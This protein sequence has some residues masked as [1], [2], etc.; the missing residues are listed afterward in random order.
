MLIR[1]TTTIVGPAQN[2]GY[3][4]LSTTTQDISP[5]QADSLLHSLGMTFISPSTLPTFIARSAGNRF[6]VEVENTVYAFAS[7]P[8]NEH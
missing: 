6:S 7:V 2:D 4:P 8:A 5:A 1:L 3:V